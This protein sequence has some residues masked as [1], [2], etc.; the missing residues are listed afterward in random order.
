MTNDRRAA[1]LCGAESHDTD[2]TEFA[3]ILPADHHGWHLDHFRMVDPVGQRLPC[4][5]RWAPATVALD[6]ILGTPARA[7]HGR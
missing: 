5:I 3:C 7:S 2:G 6:D 4:E 1:G